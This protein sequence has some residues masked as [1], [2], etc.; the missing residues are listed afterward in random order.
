M[1]MKQ[2]N[3]KKQ[4]VFIFIGLLISVVAI[5]FSLKGIDWS[6]LPL[7]FRSMRLYYVLYLI[8]L[9]YMAFFFRACRWKLLL[10][11]SKNQ[12]LINIFDATL[13]GF[14]ATNILPLRA[15]EFIRPWIYSKWSNVK[16]LT[17]LASVIVERVFD[18]LALMLLLGFSLTQITLPENLAFIVLGAKALMLIA[19]VISLVMLVA[20]I[21]PSLLEFLINKFCEVFLDKKFEILSKKIKSLS[22]EFI[23]GL[24]S[25]AGLK[26]LFLVILTSIIIWLSMASYY[27]VLLWAFVPDAEIITGATLTAILAL[28]VAAPSAPGFIGTFQFG[29]VFALCEIFTFNKELAIAFSLVAHIS[30]YILTAIHAIYVLKKR[31]LSLEQLSSAS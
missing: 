5:Y 30:Q 1:D 15:G 17:C 25:I 29:C 9:F 22:V 26:E 31:G 28:A 8:P 21:K 23:Q 16:M 3:K 20:Y 14:F 12:E 18:V 27:Q 10:P 4:K 2:N 13:L 6:A 24:K 7:A 19:S 11:D